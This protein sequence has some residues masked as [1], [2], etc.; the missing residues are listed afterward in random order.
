[1][2]PEGLGKL[3]KC[4]TV[5]RCRTRNL[6][7]CSIVSQ[8]SALLGGDAHFAATGPLSTR[9]NRAQSNPRPL[10]SRAAL[11]CH[12]PCN[13]VADSRVHTEPYMCALYAG[14]L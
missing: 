12:C 11:S 3:K 8:A 14:A 9:G 5:I 6:A 1:V 10:P 7:T 4:I 13:I 2:Q